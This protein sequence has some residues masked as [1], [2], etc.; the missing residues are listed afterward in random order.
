MPAFSY[1]DAGGGS[2]CLVVDNG[3]RVHGRVS[4]WT[5]TAGKCDECLRHENGADFDAWQS[6]VANSF[7]EI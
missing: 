5:M 3:Q 7:C 6:A 1:F 4:S 2:V